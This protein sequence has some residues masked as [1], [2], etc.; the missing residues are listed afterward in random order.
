[1]GKGGRGRCQKG[2]FTE[3]LPFAY[4]FL[5]Y[6]LVS[7]II[8]FFILSGLLV[9]GS[10]CGPAQ[11]GDTAR[12]HDSWNARFHYDLEKRRLVSSYDQRKRGRTW[13]RDELGKVDFDRYWSGRPIPSQDLLSQHKKRMDSLR[14]ERW[15]V[16]EKERLAIRAEVME[17]E[18]TGKDEK[19]GEDAEPEPVDDDMDDF[20]PGP[21][22]PQ[23]IDP[24]SNSP[25]GMGEA[26]FAPLPLAPAFPPVPEG[27]A[28]PPLDLEESPT[29]FAPLPP[30]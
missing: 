30:L 17:L 16:A 18:A 26:P 20:V 22:L 6:E 1:M 23:G 2:S 9:L 19:D 8:E 10:A 24:S 15:F 3:Y 5:Y 21:F 29:P 25:E 14:E 13:G 11:V 28:P 7:R 12:I 27:D 4:S